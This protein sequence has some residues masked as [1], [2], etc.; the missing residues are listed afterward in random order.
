MLRCEGR[1]GN[2]EGET[3]ERVGGETTKD[4]RPGTQDRVLLLGRIR[5]QEGN[6][7]ITYTLI[8]TYT[9]SDI[10]KNCSCEQ[11]YFS[12][13]EGSDNSPIPL[14]MFRTIEGRRTVPRT[15]VGRIHFLAS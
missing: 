1:R 6:A 7:G 9:H 14:Q 2:V 3:D 5:T 8:F 15:K 10:E 13:E 12:G 11:F 4:E